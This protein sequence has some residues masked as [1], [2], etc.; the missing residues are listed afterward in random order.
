MCREIKFRGKRVD[1]G[2]WVYGGYYHDGQFPFII[3]TE[4][5]YV[6]YGVLPETVG[7]FTGLKDKNGKE[8]YEGDICRYS[9]SNYDGEVRYSTTWRCS[10]SLWSI[11]DDKIKDLQMTSDLEI[12]GNIHD[13][14]ELIKE[15]P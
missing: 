14:L 10:F 3:A 12:V 7:Q 5:N 9:S 1:N 8:I 13:N 15:K 11:N 6:F 2:K 4:D